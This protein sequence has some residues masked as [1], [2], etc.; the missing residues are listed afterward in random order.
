[1][2]KSK[3]SLSIISVLLLLATVIG[4]TGNAY[5]R[6]KEPADVMS[7]NDSSQFD[8]SGFDS[9]VNIPSALPET[10]SEALSSVIS[11]T[12]PPIPKDTSKRGNTIGNLQNGGIAAYDGEWIYYSTDSGLYK[13]K[14]NGGDSVKL[15]NERVNYINVYDGWVYFTNN[16]KRESYRIKTDGKAFQRMTQSTYRVEVVNG[17]VYGIDSDDGDIFRM[18]LTSDNLKNLI[19]KG[20]MYNIN[21][22]G[23]RIYWGNNIDVYEANIDGSDI[24]CYENAGSQ[25]LIIYNGKKYTSGNLTRSNLD[26]SQKEELVESGAMGINIHNDWIYYYNANDN[27]NI[28]RIRIDGTDNQKLNSQSS[29]SICI[30]GDWVYYVTPYAGTAVIWKMHLD[31]SDNQ[32]VE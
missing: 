12:A 30:V 14:N 24:R 1:M 28:Y 10:S 6:E 29:I 21:V 27:D 32:K 8:S 5:I 22:T 3:F 17:Y 18:D 20:S 23:E 15:H 31:G 7:S 16:A 13:V 25:G 26:G 9:S 19:P 11:P 4:C 2:K